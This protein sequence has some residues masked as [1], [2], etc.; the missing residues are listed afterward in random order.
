MSGSVQ[1]NSPNKSLAWWIGSRQSKNRD[2][3]N[4]ASPELQDK[5]QIQYNS[6]MVSLISFPI[7]TKYL[8]ILGY[9]GGSA[10][11][12]IYSYKHLWHRR[13]PQLLLPES[14]SSSSP[15]LSLPLSICR[16]HMVLVGPDLTRKRTGW[17]VMVAAVTSSHRDC[18]HNFSFW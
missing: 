17:E 15:P 10:E 7:F 16:A 6:P 9:S 14:S 5:Q 1:Q 12:N 4:S 3:L 8:E 2:Q 11:M 13:A 18:F